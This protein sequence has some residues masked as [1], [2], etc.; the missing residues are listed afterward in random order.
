MW[1]FEIE[2][3]LVLG[4]WYA[5]WAILTSTFSGTLPLVDLGPE[6]QNMER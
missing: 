3:G 6:D 2:G 1:V 4:L 5:P